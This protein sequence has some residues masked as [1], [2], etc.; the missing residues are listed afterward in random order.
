[1]SMNQYLAEMFG[2]DKIA[3]EQA[4][5]QDNFFKIAAALQIDLEKTAS[6]DAN[7]LF[8][9]WALYEKTAANNGIDL[10]QYSLDS[11]AA[12]FSKWASENVFGNQGPESD[13]VVAQA[14]EF[15]SKIASETQSY[16]EII[17]I[18]TEIGQVAAHAYL[19]ELNEKLAKTD[20]VGD[21][22]NV[23]LLPE[24][25]R[26]GYLSESDKADLRRSGFRVP[27][28]IIS[29]KAPKADTTGANKDVS[30]APRYAGKRIPNAPKRDT[31]G[32]PERTVMPSHRD[33]V[34]RSAR[35]KKY[36]KDKKDSFV[37][38]YGTS[39]QR[40][41][42]L[43]ELKQYAGDLADRHGRKAKIVGGLGAAAGLAYA[44]KKVYD[45]YQDGED[46]R[47]FDILAARVALNELAE[48]G[49]NTKEAAE[50]LNWAL[51][52]ER[53]EPVSA[54]V[55]VASA[56]DPE[57]GLYAR[58]YELMDIAGY[59]VALGNSDGGHQP[60]PDGV[61][62]TLHRRSCAHESPEAVSAGEQGNRWRGGPRRL[63]R[64]RNRPLPRHLALPRSGGRL[65]TGSLW[66]HHEQTG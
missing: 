52:Q 36:L 60:F 61:G 14:T 23:P 2:T 11:V 39:D 63:P 45:R 6:D 28:D 27:S 46:K 26:Q 48:G 4:Q 1:M 42:R 41:Q 65:P 21:H 10:S 22:M 30:E 17:K 34:T 7:G 43:K 40:E 32:D 55:K 54:D 58:A 56:E 51:D 64:Q 18:G 47:A 16:E 12:E 3:S 35:L 24:K 29:Y 38:R 50:R 13:P 33:E 19:A 66:Q 5:L 15:L 44:G 20:S 37:G 9:A 53:F 59:E 49:V 8:Q 25:F 62:S 31:S 57:M